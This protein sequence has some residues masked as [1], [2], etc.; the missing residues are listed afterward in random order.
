[1]SL[2]IAPADFD[3]D[4]RM[5]QLGRAPNRVDLL[6]PRRAQDQRIGANVARKSLKRRDHIALHCILR[7]SGF[8]A[9]EQLMM[10]HGAVQQARASARGKSSRTIRRVG[11]TA[12]SYEYLPYRK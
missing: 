11:S 5:I 6:T 10:D 7:C 9:D 2:G 12:N 3:A 8:G 4:D 1:M